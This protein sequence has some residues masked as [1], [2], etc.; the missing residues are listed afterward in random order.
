MGG[1]VWVAAGDER[2]REEFRRYVS[3][4]AHHMWSRMLDPKSEVPLGHDGYLKMWSLSKPKLN[5]D[6]LL[7]DGKRLANAS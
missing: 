4:L 6:F 2:Y 7:L 3:E 1:A 5:Y